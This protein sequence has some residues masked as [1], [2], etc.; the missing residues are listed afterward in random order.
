MLQL[1]ISP[2]TGQTRNHDGLRVEKGAEFLEE[3]RF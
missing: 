1:S 3:L 2:S